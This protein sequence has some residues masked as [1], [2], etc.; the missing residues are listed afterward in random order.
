M[1]GTDLCIS[2]RNRGKL[3]KDENK[4]WQIKISQY[5]NPKFRMIM[6]LLSIIND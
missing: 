5:F 1:R 2:K 6:Y 4:F 3:L